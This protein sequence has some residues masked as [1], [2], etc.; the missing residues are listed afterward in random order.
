MGCFAASKSA[1]NNKK[2]RVTE[3]WSIGALKDSIIDGLV[4]S[5]FCPIS[6]IP[7]PYQVRG[8]LQPGDRREAE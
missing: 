8:K 1:S 3:C 7:A 4:K 5:F 2:I 6:V